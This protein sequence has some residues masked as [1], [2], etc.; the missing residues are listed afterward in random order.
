MRRSAARNESREPS[1]RQ[2]RVGELM[3]HALVDILRRGTVHDA[4]LENVAV[5]ITEVRMGP[6]LKVATVYVM[7]LG[8]RGAADVLA[9]FERHRRFLRGEVA[10]QVN[11]R[12][13]PDLRFGLD[14]SFDE[15][16]RIDALLR[17]PA[18]RGD[19]DKHGGD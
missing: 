1:Q 16:D 6:D 4:D 13:A 8:G 14:S 12:Y 3:R 18:V 9:A 15:G 17:S 11:L 7:P 2:R 5:T 19:L 10:K